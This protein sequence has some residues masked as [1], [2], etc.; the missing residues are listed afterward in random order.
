MSRTCLECRSLGFEI[1]IKVGMGMNRGGTS[2]QMWFI[3]GFVRLRAL[4]MQN[5]M[6]V[7]S[8][9]THFPPS[10]L[11]LGGPGGILIFVGEDRFPVCRHGRRN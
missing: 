1:L 5:G 9:E 4:E 10:A 7:A 11:D 8:P 3:T 2:N 6:S